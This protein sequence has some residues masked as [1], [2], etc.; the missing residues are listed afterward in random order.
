MDDTNDG[1]WNRRNVLK[2]LG[3]SA[4]LGAGAFTTTSYATKTTGEAVSPGESTRP[5]PN[6]ETER[7]HKSVRSQVPN[8]QLITLPKEIPLKYLDKSDLSEPEKNEARVALA[9]LRSRYPIKKERDGNTTWLKLAGK[10]DTSGS[11]GHSH[12]GSGSHSHSNSGGIPKE[13]QERFDKAGRAFRRGTAKAFSGGLGAMHKTSIHRK[14]TK[15]ACNEMGIDPSGI[16]DH[17]DDPDRP[18]VSIELPDV[19]HHQA[20]EDAYRGAAKE[21]MHH[22]G[23]YYDADGRQV[24]TCDHDGTHDEDFNGVGG[25][26]YAA[27]WHAN[28]ANSTTGSEHRKRVGHL[29][30]FSQDMGVPLHTGMGWEQMGIYLYLDGTTVKWG[31]NPKYDLHSQYETYV[32]DNWTGGH[33]LKWEYGSNNCS[34]DYCYYPINNVA[35]AMRHE[36]EYTGQWS[37]KVYKKILDEDTND[38]TSW[39]SST[40]DFMEK[41]STNCASENGLYTR[42]L[43]QK[44]L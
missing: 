17:A 18:K 23:Q 43:I 30:H 3:G 11:G 37:Y 8:Y 38:W 32:K 6:L 4:I 25:A 40:K 21:L 14:M 1:R 2:T 33:Y 28:E 34:S 29:T 42:G 22:V 15:D 24:Y 16:A 10:P 9:D 39:S 31:K 20:V 5:Y 12:S 44:Y 35:A 13:D 27:A 41:V 19:M 7:V 36:A 26:P